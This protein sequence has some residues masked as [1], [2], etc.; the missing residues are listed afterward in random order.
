MSLRIWL[1][2]NG[3]LKNQGLD[4]V[5][6]TNNGATIDNNGKMGKC[7]SF[8]GNHYID[9]QFKENFGIGDFSI[10]CW[11]KITQ[12]SGKTYQCIIGNKSTAAASVGCALYWNQNRKKFLWSTADGT[13]ATEIWSADTFDTL[14]YNQW[15]HIV[16]IRNNNDSKKGY[17][18]F[19]GVRKEIASIPPI[20]NISSTTSLKIGAVTPLSSTYCYT[21]YINDVRIY[22]HALSPQEVKKISQG[23][24]LHYPLNRD[25]IGQ[26]NIIKNS[27]KGIGFIGSDYGSM[28]T[29]S[30]DSATGIGRI[31]II[32]DTGKWNRWRFGKKDLETNPVELTSGITTYTF[33]SDI[34]VT[35]YITGTIALTFDFRTNNVPHSTAQCILT[36]AETDGRWHRVSASLTT[37]KQNDTECLFCITSKGTVGNIGMVVE[38]KHFKLEM[39]SIATPWCPNS[40]DSLATLVEMNTNVV[41]DISGYQNNGELIGT[42]SYTTDTPKY[43]VSTYAQGGASTYLKGV[44]LPSEAKTV[45]LWIKT[46]KNVSSAIFNDKTTGL[47]IGLLNSLL[48]ANSLASTTPFT[49]THWTNDGWNH[50]VVIN[51]NGTRSCYINGEAETQSGN[52]NYY[53]HNANEFWVWNRSYNNNYPFTGSL[54]D[55]RIY[56]TALSADEVKELYENN[57]VN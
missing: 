47:Q 32:S 53:V 34:R 2:L 40:T 20:R 3:S 14:V 10:A 49:T 39:G 44:V 15:H 18:Y 54:S 43:N 12:V 28:T 56:S 48:Y 29:H 7:Y 50:V 35:N 38:Y 24:I 37:N 4:K 45:S 42:F 8:D 22:D 30:F 17:F 16:M 46:P 36:N 9:T 55:L 25:G 57:I 51:N 33:S 13:E 26:N 11:I 52:N 27:D 6:V 1:P 31:E 21:G 19:D 41:K 23:L 5:T